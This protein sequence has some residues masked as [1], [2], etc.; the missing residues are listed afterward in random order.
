MIP[1]LMRALSVLSAVLFA[2]A[3]TSLAGELPDPLFWETED[4]FLVQVDEGQMDDHLELH[5]LGYSAD[6]RWAADWAAQRY[7][8]SGLFGEYGSTTSRR[9]FV[10]SQIALNLFP[11]PRVQLR[12]ERRD[13]Q[14][15]RFDL[16]DQRLD[17]LWY[18]GSGWAVMV[19]GWPTHLKDEASVGLGLRVGAPRSQNSLVVRV[20]NDRLL[21]NKKTESAVRFSTSPVR[22]MADGHFERGRF[23]VHGTVDYGLGYEASEAGTGAAASARSVRGHQRFADVAA[24]YDFGG[25]TAGARVTVA[26]LQRTQGGVDGSTY[27][28]DR[29]HDRIVLT[30]RRDL[31]K[32]TA[33]ALAGYAAQRD[34]FSSPTTPASSYRMDA[35]L[36]GLEAGR[37][38]GKGLE[39]RVGYLGNASRTARDVP[40]NPSLLAVDR[41]SYVDNA[42]LRALYAFQPRMSVELLLSQTLSG[43]RFGG[44]SVKVRLVL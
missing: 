12:Y 29:T 25:W 23:R 30:G 36:F 44:G 9:L 7:S 37:R 33:H 15:D 27:A 6:S 42:H 32:W 5:L 43:A 14:D 20:V 28:L 17:L 4:D 22:V 24:S 1:Y 3:Q 34:D 10:N 19:S 16:S 21:W 26:S 31:G 18:P 11:A 38:F 39:L 35:W 40:V 41:T 13:Y 2:A 8:G